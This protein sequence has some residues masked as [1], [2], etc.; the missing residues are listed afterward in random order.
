MKGNSYSWASLGGSPEQCNLYLIKCFITLLSIQK[1]VPECAPTLSLYYQRSCGCAVCCGLVAPGN[2]SMIT[3]RA[4]GVL[5][6]R[7][8][9]LPHEGE[10]RQRAA[11]AA[12]NSRPA[13]LSV[14]VFECCIV[15][16]LCMR[17]A[18]RAGP[19]F[20]SSCCTNVTT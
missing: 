1:C 9:A 7:S 19:R 6:L 8:E 20:R 12:C 16:T 18:L 4:L 5:K 11:A 13:Q 2:R 14:S 17:A 15:L 10:G 3:Q